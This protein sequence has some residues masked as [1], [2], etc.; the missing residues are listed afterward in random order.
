MA[1][2]SS[3]KASIKPGS[4]DVR[5]ITSPES[6]WTEA[7][8]RLAN[9]LLPGMQFTPQVA[10]IR[11]AGPFERQCLELFRTAMRGRRIEFAV[12]SAELRSSTLP[13]LD[14]LVQIATD[15]PGTLTRAA[16]NRE[17]WR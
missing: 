15:C 17:T 8:S 10:E 12:S 2:T 6:R 4:I 3:G 9:N 16:T 5:A 1:E 13:M 14:E 7:A 11:P